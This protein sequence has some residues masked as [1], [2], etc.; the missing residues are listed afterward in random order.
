MNKSGTKVFID[1]TK[2]ITYCKM[3]IIK[4]F[5]LSFIFLLIFIPNISASSFKILAS[6]PRQLS[7]MI[8]FSDTNKEKET[9][10]S[11][12]LP[13]YGARLTLGFIGIGVAQSSIVDNVTKGSIANGDRTVTRRKRQGTTTELSLSLWFLTFGSGK[14]TNGLYEYGDDKTNYSS[15][16]TK[17]IEF[18]YSLD[19]KGAP[20]VVL[21]LREW[22]LGSSSNGITWKEIYIGAS[23]G[24]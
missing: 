23:F 9:E 1:K 4:I 12:T 18:D 13:G 16:T 8:S 17:F 24:F 15:G 11:K 6:F 21:G 5:S 10:E 19:K 14:V 22:S 20:D 3:N 7:D 2:L